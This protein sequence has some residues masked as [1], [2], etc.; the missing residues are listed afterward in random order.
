MA[1]S[2]HTPLQPAGVSYSQVPRSFITAFTMQDRSFLKEL[3]YIYGKEDYTWFLGSMGKKTK[4]TN[5]E[6]YHWETRSRLHANVQVASYTGFAGAGANGTVTIASGSHLISGTKSPGR[7]DEVVENPRTGTFGKITNIDISTP[8]AH[9]Y[10]IEPLRSTD[11]FSM[12]NNDYLVLR[13]RTDIGAASNVGASQANPARKV[14]NTITQI[15]D[16]FKIEDMAAAEQVEFEVDGKPSYSY[17]GIQ[18]TEKRFRNVE[19]WRLIFGVDVTNTAITANG[20]AGTLGLIP[21]IQS[22]GGQIQSAAGSFDMLRF[23]QIS[24]E[25]DF[26]GVGS[27]I[28]LLQDVYHFQ[29]VQNNLFTK[30]DQGAILWGSVGGSAEVAAK[31]GFQSLTL[32][33]RSVHFKKYLNFN[34]ERTHGIVPNSAY[35][36]HF[37]MVLPTGNVRDPKE[38]V[39]KPIIEI[40]Y[41]DVPNHGEYNIYD[42]GGLAR[43]NKTGEQVLIVTMITHKGLRL[44]GA[45][46]CLVVG[47]SV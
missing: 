26:N 31:Y 47:A 7:V 42:H 1:T 46:Q 15:R 27:E 25:M 17:K 23:Q 41:Q 3:D 21:Q 33:G 39:S 12:N 9:I 18:E 22:R 37:S 34:V 35:Y 29:E 24:R 11:T 13:G 10:T 14:T 4:V 19:E 32:E 6:F 30:Y 40:C 16:D 28:Q 43:N 36:R 5:N 2:L 38:G 20:T 8:S 44:R 45:N